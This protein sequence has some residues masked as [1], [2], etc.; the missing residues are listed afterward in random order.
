MNTTN[1]EDYNYEELISV[2]GVN[3]CFAFCCSTR[4]TSR[5]LFSFTTKDFSCA[6]ISE[7]LNKSKQIKSV[8]FFKI[9]VL[10]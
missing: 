2:E 7:K 10:N 8:F 1:L 5:S 3:L 9:Y 6:F 4:L